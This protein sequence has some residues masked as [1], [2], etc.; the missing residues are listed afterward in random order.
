[1]DPEGVLIAYPG[2]GLEALLLRRDPAL[3]ELGKAQVL[4]AEGPLGDL[5]LGP[6]EHGLRVALHP[7]APQCRTTAVV[8]DPR[9]V[10]GLPVAQFLLVD[11][12]HDN[13]LI[14]AA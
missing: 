9:V 2:A 3:I 11:R 4:P 6:V 12:A 10:L 8:L 1:M 7:V 13:P 5:R 14:S